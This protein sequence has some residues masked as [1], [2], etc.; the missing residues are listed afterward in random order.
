M[1]PSKHFC[2]D[3]F[4]SESLPLASSRS[5]RHIANVRRREATWVGTF[6]LNS[7]MR[8][9]NV[10]QSPRSRFSPSGGGDF[11]RHPASRDSVFNHGPAGI[12]KGQL[13]VEG[14]CAQAD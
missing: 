14:I 13:V 7:E 10:S 12:D 3:A 5:G 11:S 9:A 2:G 6:D 1:K 4:T 8:R